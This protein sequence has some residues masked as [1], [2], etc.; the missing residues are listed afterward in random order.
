[1]LTRPGIDCVVAEQAGQLI[2]FYLF[3][4]IGPEAD[5][6]KIAVGEP[7]RRMGVGRMLMSHIL[8]SAA[9]AEVEVCF[10]EVRQSN[11]AALSLYRRFGFEE[12]GVRRAYYSSP[13][14]DALILR[15]TT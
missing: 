4:R 14:E 15:R 5:L 9:Q 13:V 10:L 2:G 7:F 8:D 11:Q 1:L 6:L 3:W 12:C